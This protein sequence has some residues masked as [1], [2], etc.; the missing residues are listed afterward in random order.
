MALSIRARSITAAGRTMPLSI[1]TVVRDSLLTGQW[2]ATGLLLSE[3][4]DVR[5]VASRLPYVKGF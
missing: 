1:P 4:E 5:R 3:F 2:D